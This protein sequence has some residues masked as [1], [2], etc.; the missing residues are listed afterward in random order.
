VPSYL[1]ARD[2]LVTVSDCGLFCRKGGFYVDPWK[3][4]DRALITHGHGDHARWGMNHYLAAAASE[5]ILRQ[6]LGIDASIN[7]IAYGERITIGD[8]MVS[9]HPAGHILGSA[10][11]RIEFKGETWIVTGDC[12][13]EADPTCEPFEVVQCDT[14][15]TESTFALP[16]YRW[17]DPGSVASDLNA[18]WRT[19][20]NLGRTSVVFAYSLGKAQRV[21]SRLDPTIGPILTHGSVQR[22]NEVYRAS[23]IP[24][25]ETHYAI[26]ASREDIQRAL[27]VAPPGARESGWLRRFV[28]YSLSFASGWMLVRGHRRRRAVDRGFVISDH[29]DWDGLL[30][31]VRETGAQRV[32]PTHGYTD[33]FARFLREQGYDATALPTRFWGEGR[34]EEVPDD[35]TREED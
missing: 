30:E 28:P 24:L 22:L 27:L 35:V 25:P 19:N 2:D 18:W 29:A 16:V 32:L 11:I 3:P 21:I 20:Q 4:V 31:I 6:R 26:S 34:E 17:P 15:I 9:F 33:Q 7:T 1:A 12:K 10:Q 8:V 13:I 5:G 14:L 23:G